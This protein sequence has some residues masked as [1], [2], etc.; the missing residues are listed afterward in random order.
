MATVLATTTFG[1][2]DT[3]HEIDKS[4]HTIE[5]CAQQQQSVSQISCLS[6]FYITDLMIGS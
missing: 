3:A 6:A 5:M 1:R 4:K 2:N